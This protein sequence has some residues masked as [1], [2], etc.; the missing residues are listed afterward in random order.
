MYMPVLISFTI[1]HYKK[2][3]CSWE[4]LSKQLLHRSSLI[5][6]E[7]L[8]LTT[9]HGQKIK[10]VQN[11]SIKKHNNESLFKFCSIQNEK[12]DH[13]ALV[14]FKLFKQFLIEANFSLKNIY[15]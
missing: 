8:A 12:I 14:I 11:D 6:P 1:A 7:L 5:K 15:Y 2:Y 13:C 4:I 10:V 3:Q 9:I